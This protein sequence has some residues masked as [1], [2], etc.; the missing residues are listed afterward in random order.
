MS[1]ST[2]QPVFN[3][4]KYANNSTIY[5]VVQ[6]EIPGGV[7]HPLPWYE[8]NDWRNI[9]RRQWSEK[10]ISDLMIQYF[11]SDGFEP[12]QFEIAAVEYDA[13]SQTTFTPVDGK[14]YNLVDPDPSYQSAWQIARIVRLGRGCFSSDKFPLGAEASVGDWILFEGSNAKRLRFKKERMLSFSDVNVKGLI[15]DPGECING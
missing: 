15:R 10:E 2:E 14:T 4:R 8:V 5:P 7:W 3:I 12:S 1:E 13:T 9:N 6:K 11:G